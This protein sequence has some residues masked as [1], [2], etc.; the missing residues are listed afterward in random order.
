MVNT[1][2]YNTGYKNIDLAHKRGP[3]PKGDY[4]NCVVCG[5]E[6]YCRPSFLKNDH[7]IHCSME[8]ANGLKAISLVTASICRSTVGMVLGA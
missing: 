5:K 4:R 6:F 2:K 8:C 3:K 7:Y 1:K